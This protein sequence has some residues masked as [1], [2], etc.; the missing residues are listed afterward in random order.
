VRHDEGFGALY[1]TVEAINNS[2]MQLVGYIVCQV[3]PYPLWQINERVL[4][5]VLPHC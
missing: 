4:L 5:G 3:V 1:R 2:R